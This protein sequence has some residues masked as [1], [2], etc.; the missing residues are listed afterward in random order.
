MLMTLVEPSTK[1][2]KQKEAL[3]VFLGLFLLVGYS[4]GSP[5]G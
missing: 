4:R 1:Q 3:G 5:G 2:P